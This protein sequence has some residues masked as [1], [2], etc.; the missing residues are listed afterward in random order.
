MVRRLWTEGERIDAIALYLKHKEA[1]SIST[2]PRAD[3]EDRAIILQC[4][5]NLDN[6]MLNEDKNDLRFDIVEDGRQYTR[7]LKQWH[8]ALERNIQRRGM[9]S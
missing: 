5:H 6:L 9:G 2:Y 7:E 3:D 4:E 8:D 1:H